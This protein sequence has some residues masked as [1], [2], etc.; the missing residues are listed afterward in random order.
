MRRAALLGLLL[1]GPASASAQQDQTI[2][3]RVIGN[4]PS[5]AVS[6][7]DPQLPAGTIAVEVIDDAGEPVPEAAV[8]LGF[9]EQSGGR[10]SEAC[11]TNDEG[12]C[13]FLELPT[14]SAH[15]YRVNVPYNGA[16][17]SSTPFRLDPKRGQ[18]VRITRLRTTTN[19]QRIFQVL[20]R[21]M[22]EFKD[23]RARV[24]QEARLTNLG[25]ATYVFPDGGLAIQLP[26]GSK[27]F[28]SRAMMTDQRVSGTDQGLEIKGSLPPGRTTL[29]W[30]YDVPVAGNTL[31]LEQQV[32]F[33]TM[34]YQVISDYIDGMS[35]EVEG[36]AVARIHEGSDRRFLVAGVMRR[37]GDPRIDSLRIHVRGIPGGGP[38]PYLASA[39]AFVFIVLGLTLV[40]RRSDES[41]VLAKA[42]EERRKELLDEIA[43]LEADRKAESVGPTFYEH[44]RRELTDELAILLRM[45]SEAKGH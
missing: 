2:V 25:D 41:Q 27:A 20:G 42:R 21:T 15:S 45:Q 26:E 37:P 18:R 10:K 33:R 14:D 24:T 40:F 30:A 23:D 34:E 38:L 9:M 11:I 4:V 44:R 5:I 31:T 32:P 35:L 7:I 36:F 29:T 39:L 22:V 6:E 1:W 8:R 16:R 43:D 19:D 12:R 3:N 17:Y 13:D 28:D